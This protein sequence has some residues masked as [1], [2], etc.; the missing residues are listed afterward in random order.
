MVSYHLTQR[1]YLLDEMH[2][3]YV[4]TARAK[5]LTAARPSVAT[6]CAHP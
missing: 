6:R 4:R 5:G 2:A 1:T 3:D